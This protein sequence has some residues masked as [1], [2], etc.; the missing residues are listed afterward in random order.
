MYFIRCFATYEMQIF[1]LLSMKYRGPGRIFR[2]IKIMTTI[3]KGM[4]N[5]SVKKK[6]RIGIWDTEEAMERYLRIL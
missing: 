4:M 1:S 2:D 3:I 6:K 5:T